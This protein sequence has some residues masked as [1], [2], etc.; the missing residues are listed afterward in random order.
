[1]KR[2]IWD[3]IIQSFQK[4]RYYIVWSLQNMEFKEMIQ[5]K[6]EHNHSEEENNNHELKVIIGFINIEFGRIDQ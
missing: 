6:L 2:S 5:T 1:M 4:N 3:S